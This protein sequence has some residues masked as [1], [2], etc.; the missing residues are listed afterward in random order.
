[1]GDFCSTGEMSRRLFLGTAGVVAVAA[2]SL[3]AN[4]AADPPAGAEATEDPLQRLIQGNGR[5]VSGVMNERDFSAGRLTR[6]QGQSPFAAV[7]SCADSRVPP[8]LIFDCGPGELFV[9]RVA[10]NFVT[11]DGLGTLDYGVAV[12]GTKLVMVLGHSNCGA[13]ASAVQ[14][15]QT[16]NNLPGHIKDLVRAM[17][18]G[19]EPELRKPGPD[20]M[21]RAVVANIR[22]NVQRLQQ[23]QP[24]I[25]QA[26]ARGELKVVGGIYELATGEVSIV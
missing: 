21:Q 19:I 2:L 9:T 13:V 8:E 26:V 5:Y 14:A 24:I 3:S 7:L 17:K 10:G 15:L 16:G 4:A 11:P 18:P 23:E 20:L 25:A 22:Y 1:M 12:L 6:E